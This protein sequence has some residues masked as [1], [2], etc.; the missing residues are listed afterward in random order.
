MSTHS[1]HSEEYQQAYDV[2][3]R[4]YLDLEASVDDGDL[5]TEM[6][7]EA[8]Q[9]LG[10]PFVHVSLHALTNITTEKF[11]DDG[12]EIEDESEWGMVYSRSSVGVHEDGDELEGLAQ[13]IKKWHVIRNSNKLC[14]NSADEISMFLLPVKVYD[15]PCIYIIL[16]SLAVA[17]DR[18]NHC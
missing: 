18:S 15:L 10:A 7:E 8:Q 4:S 16:I 1:G 2:A 13:E 9:E 17:G 11:L 6:D 5:E 12:E 14:S 3:M